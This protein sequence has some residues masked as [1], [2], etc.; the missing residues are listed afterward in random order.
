MDYQKA[1]DM[2]LLD[3]FATF[4]PE[5]TKE[6]IEYEYNKDKLANPHNE[7]RKPRRRSEQEIKCDLRYE[8]AKNMLRAKMVRGV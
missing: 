3:W 2:S 7:S 1:V 5:P 8:Y 6:E 4:A